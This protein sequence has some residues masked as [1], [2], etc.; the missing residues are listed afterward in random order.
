MEALRAELDQTRPRGTS[1]HHGYDIYQF[2][3]MLQR[4]LRVASVCHVY[5]QNPFMDTD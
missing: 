3:D 4:R 2:I 1:L 5:D